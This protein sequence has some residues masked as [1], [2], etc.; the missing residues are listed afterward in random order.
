[1]NFNM[2]GNIPIYGMLGVAGFLCGM[3]YL[4]VICK[5]LDISFS[6]IVYVYV[7]SAIAAMAGAKLLYII[8]DMPGII[9]AFKSMV[10]QSD[11]MGL[12]AYITGLLS[13]GFVFYGGV[14][15]G[16]AAVKLAS[17]YFGYDYDRMLLAIVPALPLAHAFGRTGCTVVGC[18]YGIESHLKISIV[19]KNSLYAPDGVAVFPVQITEAVCDIIIFVVLI[20]IVL[21]KRN[22]HLTL[23][24]YLLMYSCVRFVL[25]FLRG[26]KLR[27]H[28]LFLSTSQWISL[29][30]F[31]YVII[32]LMDNKSKTKES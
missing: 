15:G 32:R 21:K 31:I 2:I 4:A 22:G 27:G 19:Y 16:L 5:K 29:C 30:I 14:F 10:S 25:E 9:G 12:K 6:D 11:G 26:D 13:G 7:W 18:C 23:Y 8:I 24:M 20:Y 28:W 1:M 3:L 17:R